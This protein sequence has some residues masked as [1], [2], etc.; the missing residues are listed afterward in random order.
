MEDRTNSLFLRLRHGP[1]EYAPFFDTR[2]LVIYIALAVQVI[3]IG[4]MLVLLDYRLAPDL[5]GRL[6][7]GAALVIPAAWLLRRYGHPRGGSAI[8]ATTLAYIQ[9]SGTVLLL[10]PLTEASFAFADPQI[11]SIDRWLG[12]HWPTFSWHFANNPA[13]FR[14][15]FLAYTSFEWQTLVL[16][17]F[18]VLLGHSTRAWQLVTAATLGAIMTMAIYPFV[19]AQGPAIY[20]GLQQSDFPLLGDFPWQFGPD[21]AALKENNLRLISA[22]DVFAMV[23]VPSYHTIVGFILAWASLCDRRLRFFFVPLNV[24]M[25]IATIPIG[26]HYLSDI[27]A[28]I[29]CAC[30]AIFA[31]KALIARVAVVEII[32]RRHRNH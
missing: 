14:V 11:A 19:P 12:F 13:L 28:G 21:L 23:S 22:D 2:S 25:V 4:A 6:P 9:G 30:L 31:A 18:L 5:A 27:L 8:E 24:A 3:A 16:V 10:F 1:S 15:A 32:Q 7:F 17:P 20:Y 29:F 26:I